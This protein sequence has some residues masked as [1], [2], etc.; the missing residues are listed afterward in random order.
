M[1]QNSQDREHTKR[2][3]ALG[4]TVE[5]L[6]NVY[7]ERIKQVIFR[8][9]SNDT[10]HYQVSGILSGGIQ[11]KCR[12]GIQELTITLKNTDTIFVIELPLSE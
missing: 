9:A 10:T 12:N 1:Q 6:L 2:V 8:L 3:G 11:A 4:V 7:G 5:K